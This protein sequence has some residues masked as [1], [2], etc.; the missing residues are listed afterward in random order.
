MSI[1]IWFFFSCSKLPRGSQPITESYRMF[2]IKRE[3]L[4]LIILFLYFSEFVSM[5]FLRLLL[6]HSQL[7][8]G[9][10]ETQDSSVAKGKDAAKNAELPVKVTK[11]YR[12]DLVQ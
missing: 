5:L 10:R 9:S 12:M 11:Y 7:L 1:H 4:Q 8:E 3:L 6:L 2:G